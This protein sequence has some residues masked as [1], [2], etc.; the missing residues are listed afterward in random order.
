MSKANIY[1][2]EANSPVN[3]H[4]VRTADSPVRQ[5]VR[6]ADSPVLLQ[7]NV[8]P[9]HKHHKHKHHK[10]VH[11]QN[12]MDQG[13]HEKT[14]LKQD[15]PTVHIINTTEDTHVKIQPEGQKTGGVVDAVKAYV[16]GKDTLTNDELDSIG[17]YLVSILESMQLPEG[18]GT[19]LQENAINL[20]G[21]TTSWIRDHNYDSKLQEAIME[22]RNA[23]KAGTTPVQGMAR[24]LLGSLNN[25]VPRM[26][27]LAQMLIYD[28]EF[29]FYLVQLFEI[30]QKSIQLEVEHVKEK[31]LVK[32]VE[33]DPSNETVLVAT[34]NYRDEGFA[35]AA[36]LEPVI[37]TNVES[38]IIRGEPILTQNE[39]E[40]RAHDIHAEI[41]DRSADLI[42]NFRE[43]E[44][45]VDY[46]NMFFD[47]LEDLN[48]VYRVR[49]N[50]LEYVSNESAKAI[51]SMQIIIER[52]S[53]CSLYPLQLNLQTL[54]NS[55]YDAN[56]Y[57]LR[58]DMKEL[59]L[60]PNGEYQTREATKAKLEEINFKI[61]RF[62]E[63]YNDVL[64]NVFREAGVI[65]KGI[66]NDPMMKQISHDWKRLFQDLLFD[67]AGNLSYASALDS[68][69]VIN[70]ALLPVIRKKLENVQLPSMEID[71]PKY[72]YS[73]R[74]VLFSL[75][76][77]LPEQVHSDIESSMD[78]GLQGKVKG[79][80]N[81][82]LRFEPFAF[83]MEN[84]DFY[85]KKKGLIKYEDYG[86]VKASVSDGYIEMK[87]NF[88]VEDKMFLM[89]Y[90]DTN[91]VLHNFSVDIVE[92]KH[93]TLDKL[94][95]NVFR[96]VIKSKMQNTIAEIYTKIGT[97][98]SA[99]INHL[100]N[101]LGIKAKKV[102]KRKL[103]KFQKKHMEGEH[104]D[105]TPTLIIGVGN[106]RAPEVAKKVSTEQENAD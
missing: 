1:T 17:D 22:L 97:S 36:H 96:P 37:V 66:M 19:T 5:Q 52:V 99:E 14:M 45:Y 11:E 103:R 10:K 102:N 83:N 63:E 71:S 86:K 18:K 100:V 84:M 46:I 72:T 13:K 64:F 79:K 43:K 40:R 35:G 25:A 74:N 93:E 81:I 38:P 34:I 32:G 16:T 23:R 73:M 28:S 50:D 90:I 39:L 24:D 42:V 21:G 92:S 59:L 27:K 76:D 104:P 105:K 31:L 8:S 6:N 80:S 4:V 44:I 67:E 15:V 33:G 101:S 57:D 78:L 55:K 58:R 56:F 65:F 3:Q 20:V 89:E 51:E 75:S 95:Y 98:I 41:I 77:F 29:R 62:N 7:R 61:Q 53:G 68:F 47:L 54:Y 49:E 91:V 30:F 82:I 87:I 88:T 60:D 69:R 94:F 48:Q 9:A 106:E 70:Q 12:P 26:A 2:T 85:F